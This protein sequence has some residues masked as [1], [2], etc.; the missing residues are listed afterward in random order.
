MTA[1]SVL[2]TGRKHWAT[3]NRL[4]A[5]C[6]D[7][8]VYQTVTS[9]I[10]ENY[11]ELGALDPAD[12]LQCIAVR[13]I[14]PDQ[15]R[16]TMQQM[17]ESQQQLAPSTNSKAS[18]PVAMEVDAIRECKGNGEKEDGKRSATNKPESLFSRIQIT[19]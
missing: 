3:V 6:L 13:L 2:L 7:E 16:K 11:E 18:K 17:H 1:H 10:P 15:R 4:I 19:K 9:F 14:T 8:D 12:L 5:T